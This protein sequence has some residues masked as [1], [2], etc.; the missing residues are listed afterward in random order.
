ML[1]SKKKIRLELLEGF[2]EDIK[3]FGHQG[4]VFP[5][6]AIHEFFYA[7]YFGIKWEI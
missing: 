2:A 5:N 3:L 7:K 6:L 4:F 1:I